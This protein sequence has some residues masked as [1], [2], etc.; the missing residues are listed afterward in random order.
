MK[1]RQVIFATVASISLFLLIAFL[2]KWHVLIAAG[3]SIATYFG[4]YLIAKPKLKIGKIVVDDLPHG[5]EL[6]RLIDD[7]YEDM[8]AIRLASG[9]ITNIRIQEE[10][11]RLYTMGSKILEY[12]SD[13]PEKIRLARRFLGYYLDAS[14]EILEKYLRFQDTKLR[15]EEVVKIVKSTE[16][17]IPMMTLAFEKQFTNLMANELIDIEEDIRLLKLNLKTDS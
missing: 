10:A 12:L 5:G 15:T 16:E 1:H 17:A 6:R 13:Q 3:L 11:K 4:V 2:L 7:A 9:S 14:R 8:E